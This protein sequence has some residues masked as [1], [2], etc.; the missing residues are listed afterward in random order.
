MY[1]VISCMSYVVYVMTH[2]R[3]RTGRLTDKSWAFIFEKE[4]AVMYNKNL[5][6]TEEYEAL[7]NAQRGWDLFPFHCIA[8]IYSYWR[9]A[10]RATS[11]SQAQSVCNKRKGC[12]L[13][14]CQVF[15]SEQGELAL[16]RRSLRRACSVITEIPPPVYLRCV[17]LISK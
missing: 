6:E 2:C 1:V 13:P 8:G 11:G 3:Q 10:I 5:S 14:H 4:L 17:W 15:N 9:A 12:G 7:E 16:V